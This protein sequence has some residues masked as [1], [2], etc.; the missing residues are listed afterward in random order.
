LV[1]GGADGHSP[2]FRDKAQVCWSL[3]HLTLQHDIALIVLAEQIYRAYT[4][5][6]G[7]PYHRE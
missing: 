5:M 4:I 1:I 7:E 2:G 3:S 6:R